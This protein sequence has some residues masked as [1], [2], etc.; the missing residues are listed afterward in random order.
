[1][2]RS[3]MPCLFSG[4]QGDRATESEN[5]V[6]RSLG[7]APE[8]ALAAVAVAVSHGWCVR[9]SRWCHGTCVTKRSLIPPGSQGLRGPHLTVSVL[10]EFSLEGK[11]QRIG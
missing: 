6:S 10:S 9:E 8:A 2:S 4:V 11:T 1:M 3:D 7:L 5:C